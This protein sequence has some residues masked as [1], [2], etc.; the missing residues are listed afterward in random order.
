MILLAACLVAAAVIVMPLALST[1]RRRRTPAEL[2]GDW[3]PRFDSEFREY[4]D[5]VARRAANTKRATDVRRES[6]GSDA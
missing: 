6:R 1:W 5:R 2:R 3:W 4:A